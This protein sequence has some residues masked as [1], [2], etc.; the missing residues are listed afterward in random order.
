MLALLPWLEPALLVPAIPVAAALYLWCRRGR[1]ATM[2]LIAV[3]LAA[4]SLVLYVTLNEQ[5]YGGP[6]PWSA[7][8]RASRR[9]APPRSPSTSSGFRASSPCGSTRTSGCCAGRRRSRSSSTRRWL[10]WRSRREGLARVVP[11]RSR[12]EA[13]AELA[14][15][16]VGAV[17]L[18]AA[19]LFATIDTEPFAARHLIPALPV[20]GALVA[21]GLRHAPRVGAVLAAA[22]LAISAWQLL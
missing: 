2:G 14:L 13:A 6:T 12:A 1:R 5:L 3:E 9:R 11:E 4:A 15:A 17:L 19:F 16:V 21:W 7:L 20:A 18:T 10:L 22:T 8:P